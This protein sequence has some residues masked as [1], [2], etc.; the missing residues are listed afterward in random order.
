METAT[1]PTTTVTTV[2]DPTIPTTAEHQHVDDAGRYF[3]Y[4]AEFVGFTQADADAIKAAAPIIERHISEIVAGFYSHLLRYPPTRKFFVSPDGA[5]DQEYLELRMRHLTNFWLRTASGVYDDDYARYLDY[6]SRAHTA[7]GANPGIYIAER[8]VIGQVGFVQH[9]IS[10]ILMREL[11]HGDEAL[12]E[13]AVEAWDKLLMVILEMLSRGYGSE[14]EIE[15]FDALE[16]VDQ[17]AVTRLATTVFERNQNGNHNADACREFFV[18]TVDEIPDGSRKLVKINNLS[19]GVFHHK[20]HWYALH[21]YCLHRGG[22]VATGP[23]K[24]DTLVCPW[25]GFQYN[26]TTGQ[27]LVDPKVALDTYPVSVRNGAVYLTMPILDPAQ[28]AA[29]TAEPTPLGA[30][31]LL[32][33]ELAPGQIKRVQ[34]DGE[35][36]A[37][38][39]VGGDFFATQEKC[40]HVG[41]PLSEGPLTGNVVTCP[42]HASCFDVTNGKVMCGPATQPLETYQVTRTGERVRIEKHG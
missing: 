24:G 8:Y 6:V 5:I 25:H 39:N 13:A 30:N 40:T 38:Y 37:V 1:M 18:A 29:T 34:V 16:A 3:R 20:G 28:P 19:I 31:E 10:T 4:M 26:V 12:Q 14:R 32:A 22:P 11:R 7:H 27:L 42:W 9:A 33:N 41:G 36:V 21:N 23:L 2:T 17:G 35:D 15:S